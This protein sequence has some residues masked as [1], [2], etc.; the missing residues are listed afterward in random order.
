MQLLI[1]I[2]TAPAQLFIRI[3]HAEPSAAIDTSLLLMSFLIFATPLCIFLVMA[4]LPKYQ[5]KDGFE[6]VTIA[7]FWVIIGITFISAISS[8]LNAGL[9]QPSFAEE[10]ITNVQ[11][12][13][14]LRQIYTNK[15]NITLNFIYK[16][17]NVN[18]TFIDFLN[19]PQKYNTIPHGYG[20]DTDDIL[21]HNKLPNDLFKYRVYPMTE[22]MKAFKWSHNTVYGYLI[23]NK[24]NAYQQTYAMLKAENIQITETDDAKKYPDYVTTEVTKIEVND[25]T[26]TLTQYGQSKEI[27]IKNLHITMRRYVTDTNKKRIEKEQQEHKDQIAVD[28]LID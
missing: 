27:K 3:F 13:S 23:A 4:L 8:G 22:T 12:S 1:D 5:L 24:N 28:K 10:K 15:E 21:K 14:N 26:A 11:L 2:L 25:G 17:P 9:T 7:T 6:K 16:E 18:P 20:D 19:P